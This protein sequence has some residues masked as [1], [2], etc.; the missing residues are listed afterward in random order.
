M[1]TL[2]GLIDLTN[3]RSKMVTAPNVTE[4]KGNI[5]VSNFLN[6]KSNMCESMNIF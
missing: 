5:E 4:K 6:R 2:S 1:F 3:A